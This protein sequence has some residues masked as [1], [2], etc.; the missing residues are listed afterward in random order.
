MPSV[1]NFLDNI[2]GRYD[3]ETGDYVFRKEEKELIPNIVDESL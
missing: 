2:G 1:L 3:S